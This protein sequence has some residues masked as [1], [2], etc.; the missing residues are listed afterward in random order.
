[1]KH[2]SSMLTACACLLVCF[3]RA[4]RAAVCSRHAHYAPRC[5]QARVTPNPLLEFG[6]LCVPVH[7]RTCPCASH[8]L[9]LECLF[10]HQLLPTRAPTNRYSLTY[11]LKHLTNMCADSLLTHLLTH[12]F[13][14]SLTHF[15]QS[16]KSAVICAL[17]C[18]RQCQR[19]GQ[20]TRV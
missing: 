2:T 8:I 11:L 9:M 5:D 20:L 13:T 1:M 4:I 10:S 19:S 15:L 12:L 6:Y 17:V 18:N 14:C 16:G 3:F 7:I